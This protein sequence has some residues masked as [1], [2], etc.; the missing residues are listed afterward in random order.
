V[1]LI[2][3]VFDVDLFKVFMAFIAV[4]LLTGSWHQTVALLGEHPDEH[5]FYGYAPATVKPIFY[6]FAAGPQH[7][8]VGSRPQLTIVGIYDGTSVEVYNLTG[9]GVIASF[10]I[11]R[12]ESRRICL[13]NETYFKVVS[14]KMVSVLLNGGGWKSNGAAVV[15]M[16]STFYPSIEGGHVGTEFILV[17]INSTNGLLHILFVEDAHVT[18]QDAGGKLMAELGGAVGEAKTTYLRKLPGDADFLALEAYTV[19]STGR[20]MLAGLAPN[21]FR[22]LPS[23]TGGFVGKHF[24]AFQGGTIM[25][26]ALEDAEVALYDLKRPGWHITLFGPDLTIGLSD[27]EWYNTSW[28]GAPI[29]IDSTGNISVLIGDCGGW[30]GSWPYA[31]GLSYPEHMGDDV[32]FVVVRPG[33]EFGFFVPTEALIFA[34]EESA[35][36]VDGAMVTAKEDEYLS[37]AHG[38]HRVKASAPLTIEILGH[39]W[40]Y[41]QSKLLQLYDNYASYLVSYEGFTE[42]YPEPPGVGGLEII[43][44]MAIGVAIPILLVIAEFIRRR[45]TKKR[46]HQKF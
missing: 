6:S 30:H 29:R 37:L 16:A 35:I 1:I 12:M 22:Y 45:G 7:R 44:Y 40:E 19:I 39:G 5:V 14:E 24:A 20:I 21:S 34:H 25:L 17:P 13:A 23:L 41:E 11:D 31:S 32:S 10:T 15:H 9:K 36:E 2:E 8:Y 26:V 3:F 4:V 43:P 38:V 18:I 27:G 33:Q 46:R 42:N 28:V